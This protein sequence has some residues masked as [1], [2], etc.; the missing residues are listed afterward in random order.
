[1]SE[2]SR[3]SR[4]LFA[5]ARRAG[6]SEAARARVRAGVEA[7]VAAIAAGAAAGAAL[8]AKALAAGGAAATGLGTKLLIAGAVSAL[9]GVGGSAVV[10]TRRT[11]PAPREASAIVAPSAAPAPPAPPPAAPPLEETAS[12]APSPPPRPAPVRASASASAAPAQPPSIAAELAR[13]R[14]AQAALKDGDPERSLRALDELSAQ[15]PDGA[16][17][18]ERMAARVL[19]LCAAGRVDEARVAASR[20]LA[21]SPRS[22]QADR[23]RGSCAFQGP[24]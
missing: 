7:K 11:T 16:L 5:E 18:E 2:L 4:A 22:V 23:V 20:F 17:R 6:P 21:E 19:A 13:L 10:L 9:I 12:P 14:E 3:K 24:R 15:H 8:E 1:V